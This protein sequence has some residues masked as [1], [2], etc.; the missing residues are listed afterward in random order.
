MQV[1]QLVSADGSRVGRDVFYNP[2]IYEA[3]RTR[4]YQRCWLYV[5][6]ESQI[7]ESGDFVASYMGE[8]PVIVTR[9]RDGSIGV[10][11]NSCSH[12]GTR[13]CRSHEG[14]A[15]TFTCSYHGWQF[16]NDGRLLGVPYTGSYGGE[17]DKSAWGLHRAAK[18]DHCFGLI[19]ATFDPEAVPLSDYLGEDLFG[20]LETV[21][22]RDDGGVRMLGG[23]HRWRL[24]C[25]WKVPVENH[26]P[27]M[28]HIDP[29]HRAAFAALGTDEF[30]LD[31]G[32]QATT[33][34]GHLFAARYLDEDQGMDD[35][36]PGFGMGAFPSAGPFLRSKQPAADDRLGPVRCRLSPIAATVFPNLSM[37]PTNF[38][39]R[40]SHPRGP[41][42]TE[43]W[44]WCFVPS[45]ASDEV[46]S[47]MLATYENMLGPG[48]ILEAEDGENWIAMTSGSRACRTDGRPYNVGM[49][50]GQ[51]FTHSDLPGSLAPLWSEH[52]Q[53]GLYRTW[54]RWM[55]ADPRG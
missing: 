36:L 23:V 44:S 6:H 49:G 15:R 30:W 7:P 5:A 43:I 8:E 28:I 10:L 47:E 24:D 55:G 46:A 54:R 48:G 34:Q 12:R 29:S 16:D 51:E 52:N 1:D 45:D 11:V 33:E 32:F 53:R 22:G 50:I 14:N 9:Q 18:V 27:D 25:N 35:R 21:F 39:I 4:I 26:A 17:L 42:E 19:F 37:V 20:Y 2:A 40:V 38:T 13:V 3:E 41:G 31:Q